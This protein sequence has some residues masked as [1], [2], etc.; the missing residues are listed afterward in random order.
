M[1]KKIKISHGSEL[2]IKGLESL[3]GT[4]IIL[5]KKGEESAY[6]P[7][8]E[9]I[10]GGSPTKF[11]KEQGLILTGQHYR[12]LIQKVDEERP[13]KKAALLEQ[14]GW[15]Q[16]YFALPN[17]A[18]H[19]P[20]G[21]N[22][23]KA[24]YAVAP[25]R[26]ASAG[27]GA[28]WR[29]NVAGLV[30]DQTLPAF[31][32]MAALASP[33]LRLTN[34]VDNFGFEIVGKKATGKTTCLR[35]MA[36][37]VGPA[38]DQGQGVYWQTLNATMA[39]LETAMMRHQDMPFILDEAGMLMPKENRKD[40]AASMVELAFRLGSGHPKARWGEAQPT[41]YRFLFFLSS[42]EPTSQTMRGENYDREIAAMDR[43][44]TLP[45]IEGPYG[46]FDSLPE[47]YQN[48]IEF[49]TA[50]DA[51]VRD[52]YGL[53]F[54]RFTQE[55]VNKCG[56]N[57]AAL[58]QKIQDLL[59]QFRDTVDVDRDNGSAIRVCDA[60]GLVYAAGVLAQEAHI[61]P[62]SYCCLEIARD[63]YA[64]H[65]ASRDERTNVARVLDLARSDTVL[66]V[67][68]GGVRRLTR[69]ELEAY[70]GV[71]YTGRTSR[72][73]LLTKS[74]L[75]RLFPLLHSPS[76]TEAV[77]ALLKFDNDRKTVKRTLSRQLK[78]CRLHCIELDGLRDD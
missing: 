2:K 51:A 68:L 55:L 38:I 48:G 45:V 9:F 64:R 15:T 59:N 56:S 49:S 17:G 71:V 37:V 28:N 46:I 74:Q 61:L 21:H 52:H 63:A 65:L 12:E 6:I 75:E 16:G 31:L 53:A 60:F 11:L 57:E 30:V 20:P 27:T 58:R 10:P 14:T 33:L 62:E 29:D 8:V 43:L 67:P 1:T 19:S 44:L 66:H 77:S 24:I 13:F 73:L 50:I 3:S 69:K 41:Q 22:E 5:A 23:G 76:T 26:C 25:E 42:N 72:E 7:Y 36:S 35:L 4:K 32:I 18:I 54:N 39:G 70:D 34:R 78:T 47:G 40:R